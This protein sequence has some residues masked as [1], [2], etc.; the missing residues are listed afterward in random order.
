MER[1][2]R[3]TK[4][5]ERAPALSGIFVKRAGIIGPKN[6]CTAIFIEKVFGC[7]VVL[8]KRR[9]ADLVHHEVQ[10]P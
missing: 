6:Y 7:F 8:V 1:S 9:R 5:P 4:S 2:A 3:T 10:F